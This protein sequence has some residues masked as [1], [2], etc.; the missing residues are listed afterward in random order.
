MFKTIN[1][2]YTYAELQF[3]LLFYTGVKLGLREGSNKRLKTLQ[4]EEL[5]F[6]SP[7]IISDQIEEN[8]KGQA[9]GTYGGGGG[10]RSV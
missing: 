10:N 9:S 4:N 5:L 1:T 8:Y 7:N 6:S 2:I 3:C